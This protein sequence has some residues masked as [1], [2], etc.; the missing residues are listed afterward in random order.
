MLA[1]GRLLGIQYETILRDGL[2]LQLAAHANRLAKQLAAGLEKSGIPLLAAAESNQV[3]PI[4]PDSAVE[5]LRHAVEFEV[6]RRMDASHIC[7]R[8]VTAWHT[9]Q[10]DVD[11]L[12][13]LV[14]NPPQ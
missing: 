8:F 3:F 4:L 9:T 7:I 1:K 5:E 14:E 13:E 12:L 11:A 6:E 10:E 2:Y